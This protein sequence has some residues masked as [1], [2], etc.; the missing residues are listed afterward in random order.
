M[1][2]DNKEKYGQDKNNYTDVSVVMILRMTVLPPPPL[3]EDCA[4]G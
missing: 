3:D 4:R 2:N 1:K